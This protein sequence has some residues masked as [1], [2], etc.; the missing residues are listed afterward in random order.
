MLVIMFCD[1]PFK[2]A[3]ILRQGASWKGSGTMHRMQVCSFHGWFRVSYS[4]DIQLEL[5]EQGCLLSRSIETFR[6]ARRQMV[7]YP[8]MSIAL[9]PTAG[10]TKRHY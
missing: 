8:S 4:V 2:T 5:V 9:E 1:G 3:M 6:S 7:K 10:S